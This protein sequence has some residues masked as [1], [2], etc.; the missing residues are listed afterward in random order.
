MGI[1]MEAVGETSKPKVHIINVVACISKPC[2]S[3]SRPLR[4]YYQGYLHKDTQTNQWS[5]DIEKVVCRFFDDFSFDDDKKVWWKPLTWFSQMLGTWN[6]SPNNPKNP[7][8]FYL[9]SLLKEGE[10]EKLNN[11]V[12][13]SLRI[14]LQ[15]SITNCCVDYYILSPIKTIDDEFIKRSIIIHEEH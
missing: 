12:F 10:W 6:E 14:I 5:L 4:C 13:R 8:R 9:T 7:V 1:D 15:K 11:K 3:K 2:G